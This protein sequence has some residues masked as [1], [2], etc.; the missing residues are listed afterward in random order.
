VRAGGAATEE[1]RLLSLAAEQRLS[2]EVRK[3]VFVAIMGSDDYIHAFD[4]ISKLK[5]KK[6]QKAEVV[7]V[8]MHCCGAEATFNAFY[9]LLAARLCSAHREYKFAFHFA[10]WDAFKQLHD[11]PLNKVAN[12]AKL[13]AQ[14][15]NRGALPVTVLKVVRWHDLDQRALFFWQVHV[16]CMPST[17]L[18]TPLTP[19][20]RRM[21]NNTANVNKVYA[22]THLFLS[23]HSQVCFCELLNAS[24]DVMT[25]TMLP[26]GSDGPAE[27]RDGVLLFIKRD[28]E[29]LVRRTRKDLFP[30]LS[31][32]LRILSPSSG[33]M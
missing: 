33:G 5:V 29:R 7:R 4:R 19:I 16:L 3:A 21:S 6:A 18:R 15:L 27:L 22:F 28:L 24:T 32:L 2:T 23:T 26:L 17:L 11:A 1:A 31:H 14:L 20:A 9:A 30:A 8:L 25:R 13:L 12:T 10:M